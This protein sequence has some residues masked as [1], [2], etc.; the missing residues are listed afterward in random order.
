MARAKTKKFRY[1]IPIDPDPEL[2]IKDQFLIWRGDIPRFFKEALGR[3]LSNQQIEAANLVKELMDAKLRASIKV[4]GREK[5]TLTERQ[6][7]LASKWGIS[8]HS[9]KG[10][11][12]DFFVAGLSIWILLVCGSAGQFKGI[13]T[14][15]SKKQLEDVYSSEVSK[16]LNEST[17]TI[18]GSRLDELIEVTRDGIRFIPLKNQSFISKRTANTKA[19]QEEQAKTLLGYHEKYMMIVVDEAAGISDAVMSPLEATLTRE[20]NF[21]IMISNP[22]RATG[23]FYKSYYDPVASKM[24]VKV[25]WDG[26][27]S[28]IDTIV[29]GYKLYVQNQLE[30]YG[31]ESTPYR[32]NVKGLP[33]LQ[34]DDIL[35]PRDWIE[36]AINAE[37]YPSDSDLTV[38][39]L[40]V[41]RGG[42]PSILMRHV[43]H[44]VEAIK[45]MDYDSGDPVAAATEE[46]ID[47]FE[48]DFVVVDE[49]GVGSSV[50]DTLR[51]DGY[52]F[53]ACNVSNSPSF[54]DKFYRLRDE[55]CWTTRNRFEKRIIK[56]LNDPELI[57]ELSTLKVVEWEPKIRIISKKELKR[58]GKK[59]PNKADALILRAF[60]RPGVADNVT[61]LDRYASRFN[62]KSDRQ[63]K[64]RWMVA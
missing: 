11:G 52:D 10:L 44:S 4:T 51:R 55:L 35:I 20:C 41:G 9:G 56:I 45:R 34:S 59:S 63:F 16:L 58:Q 42:D 21:V 46:W 53:R 17:C 38:L 40:D 39:T 32:I 12:K 6:E 62:R 61:E 24:W 26:E 22:T 64:K 31:K 50:V 14:A 7:E 15:T 60:I 48:P 57:D 37:F 47:L 30:A 13:A 8:I 28:N 49:I 36:D 19:T 29:P 2:V 25:R 1:E 33:P 3:R 54:K 27:E 5:I 18:N 43:G 23:Y